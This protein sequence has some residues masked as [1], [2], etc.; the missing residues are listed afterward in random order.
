MTPEAAYADATAHLT[1]CLHTYASDQWTALGFCSW[2]AGA[3]YGANTTVQALY[4]WQAATALS[5]L[6]TA[7][8]AGVCV[9]LVWQG[10][11]WRGC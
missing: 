2:N 11:R 5:W 3:A 10:R 4:A 1:A 8:L 6:C 9:W 7:A